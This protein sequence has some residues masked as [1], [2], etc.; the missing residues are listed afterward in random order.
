MEAECVLLRELAANEEVKGKKP[1]V[2]FWSAGTDRCSSRL[3]FLLALILYCK[4]I[5][6]HVAGLSRFLRFWLEPVA[7]SADTEVD[8]RALILEREWEPMNRVGGSI[9]IPTHTYTYHTTRGELPQSRHRREYMR[10]AGST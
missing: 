9:T 4:Y 10:L 3:E 6:C 2:F 8:P 1:H 7:E 5:V